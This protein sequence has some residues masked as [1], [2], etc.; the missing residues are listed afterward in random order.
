MPETITTPRAA[1]TPVGPLGMIVLRGD[2][3]MLAPA[4]AAETGCDLPEQRMLT[5][6][7]AHACLW[8]SPDE[9]LLIC[10]HADARALA[11][12]MADRLA[13][14]FATVAEVSDARS[15][16]DMSGAD[17]DAA[18]ARLTP[19]NLREI[20]PSEVRRSRLAQVAGAF[21]REG[22]GWRIICFRSVG[23]YV[24]RLL[25]NAAGEVL[26]TQHKDL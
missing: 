17:A 18:L 11:G 3:A 24:E 13:Q 2:L 8:M 25:R 9:L 23:E 16:F 6:S 19:A 1:V 12:R 5:R 15:V 26:V 7:G 10:P 20:A 22:E 4:V 21:W 14:E